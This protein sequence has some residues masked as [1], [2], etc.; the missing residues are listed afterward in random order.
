MNRALRR[1]TLSSDMPRSSEEPPYQE[2][3]LQGGGKIR[4]WSARAWQE[5]TGQAAFASPSTMP[6]SKR[7][8]SQTGPIATSPNQSKPS[9]RS[10][11][12][13]SET[14]DSTTTSLQKSSPESPS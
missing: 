11:K 9:D 6:W 10:S 2:T 13:L 4:L 7:E 8:G 14:P 3:N 1:P 12:L 5:R